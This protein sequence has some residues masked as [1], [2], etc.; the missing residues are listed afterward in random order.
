MSN[1]KE[2]YVHIAK[3]EV[4]KDMIGVDNNGR[5]ARCHGEL[6]SGFGLA[7]GSF[8]VYLYCDKCG[9]VVQKTEIHDDF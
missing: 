3:S 6:E 5:C 7:G 4:R 2:V 1:E 8:G 9:E